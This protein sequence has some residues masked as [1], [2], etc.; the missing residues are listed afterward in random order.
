M[1]S[2]SITFPILVYSTVST[3]AD[4]TARA[5]LKERIEETGHE[6][7]KACMDRQPG[8]LI[9]TLKDIRGIQH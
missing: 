1:K 6:V 2:R 8:T 9:R 5:E 3:S 7:V 4:S